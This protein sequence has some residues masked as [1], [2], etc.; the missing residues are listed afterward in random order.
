MDTRWLPFAQRTSQSWALARAKA[1]VVIVRL[2]LVR[3]GRA[4]ALTP[5]EDVTGGGEGRTFPN[6]GRLQ[7]VENPRLAGGFEQ[8]CRC[9]EGCGCDCHFELHVVL[10]EVNQTKAMASYGARRQSISLQPSPR[11]PPAF[12]LEPSQRGAHLYPLASGCGRVAFGSLIED[13]LSGNPNALTLEGCV[14]VIS[15]LGSPL[16]NLS[17]NTN[18]KRAAASTTRHSRGM[19]SSQMASQ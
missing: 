6:F 16:A 19:T 8:M 2:S 4:I 15:C 18:H 5:M 11:Q 12:S 7:S 17:R 13:T 1:A 10:R 3:P 9:E 14:G